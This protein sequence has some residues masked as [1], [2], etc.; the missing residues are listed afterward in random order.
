MGKLQLPVSN[1][2]DFPQR[3]SELQW[4]P[5]MSRRGRVQG[6]LQLQFYYMKVRPACTAWPRADCWLRTPA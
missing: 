1:L 2:G 6:H 4:Y 5:L 3:Y